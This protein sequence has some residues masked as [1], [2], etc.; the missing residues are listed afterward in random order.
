MHQ[1]IVR[2]EDGYAWKESTNG[3]DCYR[4][5]GNQGGE[6]YNRCEDGTCGDNCN[7]YDDSTGSNY[8]CSLKASTGVNDNFSFENKGKATCCKY[9]KNADISSTKSVTEAANITAVLKIVTG[10]N[11]EKR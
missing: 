1:D 4:C 6:D 5:H 8:F 7:S 3:E 2:D 10:A 9:G 11:I